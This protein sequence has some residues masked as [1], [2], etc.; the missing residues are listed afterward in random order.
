MPPPLWSRSG[1][2]GTPKRDQSGGAAGGSAAHESRRRARRAG[3]RRAL[4]VAALAG[5]FAAGLRGPALLVAAA[6]VLVVAAWPSRA[7]RWAAGAAGERSTARA[8][9]G[10]EREGY[11]VLHDVR[12]R[13]RRWNLD[14]VL[15][16]P[17]GLIVVET[18]QWRRA[19][20]VHRRWPKVVED[21]VGWQVDAVTKAVG[22][23]VAVHGF[24][25]VH[26]AKVRRRWWTGARNAPIGDARH[27]RRWLRRLPRT[28]AA[29]PGLL[30]KVFESGI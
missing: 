9:E 4:A 17:G 10:L 15:L 22:Q 29:D 3:R 8:L 2:P 26:G 12:L 25:C 13:G 24:V 7:G 6:A 21:K 1:S 28:H 18:K 23:E 19:V 20:T 30:R 5:S 16:G 27:L 11:A 14:H